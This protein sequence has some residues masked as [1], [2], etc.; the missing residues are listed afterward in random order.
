M[1]FEKSDRKVFNCVFLN[2]YV[3]G[4]NN[5]LKNKPSKKSSAGARIV[6]LS[7]L[8]N[9]ISGEGSDRIVKLI[10]D[11]KNV[12]EFL[13]AKKMNLTINQT[14]NILYKLGDKGLVSFVRK[15]DS[16][17]GGWY[18]YFWTLDI[19][20]ALGLLK[21]QISEKIGKIEGE[22]GRRKQERFYV[23]PSVGVEYSEE[24]ALEHDFICPETGEVLELRESVELI[25]GLA[26]EKERL[27]GILEL[28][29]FELE[30]V[31]DKEDKA[32]ARRVK[33]EQ[34]KKEDER[35]R[36]KKE[37]DKL[38]KKLGKG[39]KVI[40]KA[41]KIK[42]VKKTKKKVNKAKKISKKKV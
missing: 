8:I 27:N 7:E 41:K 28:V 11:K 24:Q 13:I 10:I 1:T 4:K 21:Q 34:K 40:K 16:K 36:K 14:R 22:T 20:R 6:L 31:K 18:T 30:D 12:N 33:I 32:R 23:S 26:K 9:S 29:D 37:R 17:K 38:K 35:A 19:G 42:K 15:K 5:S 39:K 3:V 25:S 2:H